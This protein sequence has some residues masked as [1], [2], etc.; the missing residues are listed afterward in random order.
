MGHTAVIGLQWG[1]EGKG[2]IVDLLTQHFD[3]VVRYA[4]GA[5]AGHTVKIGDESYALHLLPSG[6]LRKSARNL[7]APGVV[8]DLEILSGEIDGLRKRNIHVGD[9]LKISERAH[10][11]MP[12]H[13]MQDK[14][15]ESSA[16][17]AGKIGTT[18]KG[19]GP[20]YADKMLRT[21]ALRVCDLEDAKRFRERVA[22]IAKF[23]N[24]MFA[25]LYQGADS[26]D[27][28]AVANDYLALAEKLK[29]HIADTTQ[30]L[31]ERIDAGD[32]VLFEGAQGS[33]LDINHG[34]YPYVTSSAC[35]A[36]G[37]CVGAGVAPSLLNSV[38][39]VVKAYSTRVGSGP[40]PTEQNNDIGNRIR[41]RGHEYGTTTGR[42]RRCGWF[43]AVAARHAI[44]LSGVTELCV[45]HLDT[46]GTFDEVRICT[47][48][49]RGNDTF[50]AFPSRADVLA[51]VE[52][53]FE[54]LPGWSVDR[55]E[56]DSFEQLPVEAR[57]YIERL[58]VILGV[59]I[60]L[61]SIGPERTATLH[62]AAGVGASV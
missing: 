32:R 52:P 16:G 22:D 39:G 23:K 38:V 40:F 55:P 21:T 42:P 19:I 57:S 28:D 53:V 13:K 43:D 45:M 58:E 17:D 20:C 5:N 3:V 14:L 2:K 36:G 25:A 49:R 8:V 15:A 48:Y 34:T 59:P 27:A 7:V 18:A 26:I 29:P 47:A 1:D 35:I 9:N 37:V 44:R 41:E 10:L 60:T 50:K 12:W 61:V 6:I 56:V 54:T 30:I 24:Q 11:V 33:M 46:L 62:R 31:H 4:G 51:S